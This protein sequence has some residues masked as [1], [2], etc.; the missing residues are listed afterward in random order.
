MRNLVPDALR[1]RL[2]TWARGWATTQID[3]EGVHVCK[4]RS[5]ASDLGKM[6]RQFRYGALISS[7]LL[8]EYGGGVLVPEQQDVANAMGIR[9]EVSELFDGEYDDNSMPLTHFESLVDEEGTG[10]FPQITPESFHSTG[11]A[12]L[13]YVMA[14]FPI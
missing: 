9:W 13:A 3:E 11:I 1:E 2:A 14:G 5:N 12:W 8:N 10:S 4:T 6:S 7:D